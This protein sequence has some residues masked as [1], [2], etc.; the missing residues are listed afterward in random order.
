M[1][2]TYEPRHRRSTSV[3]AENYARCTCGNRLLT[4]CPCH[5]PS[6]Y[7]DIDAKHKAVA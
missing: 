3:Y 4:A 1:N 5:Y 7:A 2:T 6:L